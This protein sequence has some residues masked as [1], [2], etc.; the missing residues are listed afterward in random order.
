MRK[1]KSMTQGQRL[2]ES[3]AAVYNLFNLHRHSL[4][5]RLFKVWRAQYFET[6]NAI[7]AS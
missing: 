7:T 2:L 1:F 5:R 6:W 4:T 3:H